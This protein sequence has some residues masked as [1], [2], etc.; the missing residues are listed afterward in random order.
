MLVLTF[1]YENAFSIAYQKATLSVCF[2]FA[3]VQLVLLPENVRFDQHMQWRLFVLRF[4]VFIF[5]KI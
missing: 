5:S 1:K 4:G 3:F 2:V